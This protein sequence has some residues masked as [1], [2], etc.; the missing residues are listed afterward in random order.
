M[1]WLKMISSGSLSWPMLPQLL[2]SLL[3]VWLF[4]IA[5]IE[6]WEE[7]LW[8]LVLCFYAICLAV[9]L[10]SLTS[11]SIDES[12]SLYIFLIA[13]SSIYDSSSD[14]LKQLV[15]LIFLKMPIELYW[16]LELFTSSKLPWF[17]FFFPFFAG[18]L[19]FFA[20]DFLLRDWLGSLVDHPNYDLF[21]YLLKN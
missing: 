2:L 8:S 1:I 20:L 13:K 3:S 4:R 18:L 10:M 14:S 7:I 19:L 21:G 5:S 15:F 11:H 16:L 17:L 9:L 12:E 6:E